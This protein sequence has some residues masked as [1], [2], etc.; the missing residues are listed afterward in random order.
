L[1]GSVIRRLL[2]G[3]GL[4]EGADE[5][6]AAYAQPSGWHLRADFIST[7]DGVIEVDGRS[8]PLGG[9]VDRA[10]FMAMRAVC[11][12]VLI[13]AGTVRAENYG[14]VKLDAGARS[15]RC[16]R[17]QREVPRLAIVSA[18]ADLRPEAR[19]F[20]VPGETILLTSEW[21]LGRHP[22]LKEVADVV[23]CGDDRVDLGIARRELE[24]RGLRRVCCEG[25]P[26]LLRSLLGVGL[27]DELCL[28]FTPLV[29]GSTHRHLT[30]EGLLPVI[31]P[32]RL[33]ALLEGDGMLLTRYEKVDSR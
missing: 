18:R 13:G 26:T 17:G 31:A 24:R 30:G 3:A 32:F 23:T 19:V 29:A 14:Q 27:V 1:N 5:L 16:E 11:D 20:A 25:G 10:A 2:P 15:R 33:A 9:A 6:E 22:D 7:L 12:A 4:V 21:G 28:T 8:G